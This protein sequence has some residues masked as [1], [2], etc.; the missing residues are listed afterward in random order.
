MNHLPLRATLD[1]LP[2]HALFGTRSLREELRAGFRQDIR[3]QLVA[4]CGEVDVAPQ[5][6]PDLLVSGRVEGWGQVD[7][8]NG[9][10]VGP[11]LDLVGERRFVLS[12]LRMH[13]PFLRRHGH[14]GQLGT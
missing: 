6:D 9:V 2:G 8:R 13:R 11:F 10:V 1:T 7:I 12:K 4:V 14:Q 3:D 5:E